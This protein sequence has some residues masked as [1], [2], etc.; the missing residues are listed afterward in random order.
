MKSKFNLLRLDDHCTMSSLNLNFGSRPF[1]LAHFGILDPLKSKKAT[2]NTS[3]FVL[4][5]RRQHYR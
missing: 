5:Q 2:I 3:S 1:E 4:F